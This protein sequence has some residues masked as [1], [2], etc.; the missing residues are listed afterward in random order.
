VEGVGLSGFSGST[1]CPLRGFPALLATGGAHP[2]R[3]SLRERLKQGS[4]HPP[5]AAMLGCTDSPENPDKPTQDTLVADFG[6]NASLRA[7]RGNL[8]T[9]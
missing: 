2:T 5:V 4:L 3:R 7:K 6:Q 1:V 8:L 9:L